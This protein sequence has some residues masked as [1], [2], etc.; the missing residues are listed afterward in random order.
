MASTTLFALNGVLAMMMFGIALSL[1]AADF[2]RVIQQPKGPL[3]G[4]AAQFLVLP[5]GTFMA[6]S[7]IP[8]PAE[9]ALGLLLVS[10]CPGGS[11]SNIM[12]FLANGNTAMS[13]SMT[14][15]ASLLASLLTPLNFMFYASLNSH[16]DALLQEIAVSTWDMLTIVFLVLAI[17]LALGLVTAHKLPNFARRSEGFFRIVSLAALFA[18]VAIALVI[19]WAQFIAGASLFVLAVVAHNAIALAIGWS[20]AR[21]V[22][23]AAAE[24]RAISLEVGLQNSGLGLG[25]IF[26]YFADLSGMAIIAAAWGIWHLVSGLG[27][28]LFWHYWDRNHGVG[29]TQGAKS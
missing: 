6:I 26:T 14:G 1:K 10:C 13:V 2:K 8:M 21:A 28:T 20:A 12:T 19:N 9:I 18:F 24:R 3:I 23:M 22:G 29:Q 7:V 25:I 15:I 27:L 5:F 16:T 17:P 4:L 11:F